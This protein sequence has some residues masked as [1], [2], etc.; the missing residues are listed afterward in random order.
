MDGDTVSAFQH[1]LRAEQENSSMPEVYHMRALI[2]ATKHD[3]A[4][5][6]IEV[7]KALKLNPNFSA[8]N[9][10]YGKL[11]IDTG[12]Y[13]DAIEPLKKAANDPLYREA[14]K[15]WTNLGILY[16]R[17]LD[18][19]KAMTNL[20]AAIENSPELSCI[21]YYYRGHIEM[22]QSNFKTAIRDYDRA[23]RRY[24]SD[25]RDAQLALGIAFERSKQYDRA[26]KKFVEIRDQ[27]PDTPVA[28]QA[29]NHLRYLP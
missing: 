25:F 19:K 20:N 17:Q 4:N 15:S 6:L 9:N 10:T 16:Y 3:F 24:C 18:N 27:Y 23:T 8:A 5:A 1:C 21:A 28:D 12:K 13:S 7:K 2:Y 29:A 26:R 14:Y 22:Q 11:L